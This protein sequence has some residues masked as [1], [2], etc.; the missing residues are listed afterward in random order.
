[1]YLTLFQYKDT[2]NTYRHLCNFTSRLITIDNGDPCP[3]PNRPIFDY[4]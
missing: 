4:D 3:H 2:K 1:M